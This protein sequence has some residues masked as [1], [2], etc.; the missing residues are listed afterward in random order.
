MQTIRRL[1]VRDQVSEPI[2][3]YVV[4]RRLGKGTPKAT[5]FEHYINLFFE[6]ANH[7][8][9]ARANPASA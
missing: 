5:Y 2:K 7:I 9:P 1:K 3:Q 4:E 6:M 8:C